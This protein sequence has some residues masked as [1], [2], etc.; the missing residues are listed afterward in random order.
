MPSA[1][2]IHPCRLATI[3]IGRKLGVS[4]PFLGRGGGS[5][6]NTKLPGPRPTSIPSGI[7]IHPATTDMGRQLWGG[8]A[9]LGEA[10]LCPHL[11]QCGQGR[12]LSACQV[13]I[14]P[15]VW[16]QYT[17]TSQTG[18][19]DRTGQTDNGLIAEREPFYKR[20]A[21]NLQ[22]NCPKLAYIRPTGYKKKQDKTYKTVTGT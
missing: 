3:D 22:Q 1:I 12:D 21:K 18:Q 20:S 9:P 2:L 6:S 11:T 7:L 8:C 10:E 17:P 14:H 5:P 13:L 16:P 4:A 19:I 15:T